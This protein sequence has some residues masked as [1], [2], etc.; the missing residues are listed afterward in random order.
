MKRKFL[1]D[2]GITDGD[3]IKAIIEYHQGVAQDLKDEIETAKSEVKTANAT[4]KTLQ[5][6]PHKPDENQWVKKTDYDALKTKYDTDIAAKETEFANFKASIETEKIAAE[7]QAAIVSQ[8]KADGANAK[9]TDLLL[10]AFD[11]SK[12]EIE[13][14]K[15]KDWDNIS[16]PIKETY[17]D[18]FGKT[19]TK[20]TDKTNP[21]SG[22]NGEG[23]SKNVNNAMNNLIRGKGEVQ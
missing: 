22:G 17:A 4:I 7:K 8:L 13:D 10:K 12:I 3:T 23:T 15:V 5:N 18:V 16:K 2:L 20:G 9:L 14:G 19:V 6:E 11:T 21:P 1:T